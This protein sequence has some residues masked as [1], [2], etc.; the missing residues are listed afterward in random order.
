L[1]EMK[2]GSAGID[3]HFK[4]L[5]DVGHGW[6]LRIVE[7]VGDRGSVNPASMREMLPHECLLLRANVRFLL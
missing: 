6:K 2:I 4:E 7:R 3:E 1:P 5:V